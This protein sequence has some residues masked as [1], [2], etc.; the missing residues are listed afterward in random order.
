VAEKRRRDRM[1]SAS[2][3]YAIVTGASSGLGKAIAGEL[4]GRGHNLVLID[5]PGTGLKEVCS[6]LEKVC[7]IVTHC[8]EA[9]MCK[10]ETAGLIKEFTS[11][12][13]FDI[14]ILINNVGIGYGGEIGQYNEESISETVFLNI[15]SATLLT[16]YFIAELKSHTP[17]FILNMGSFSGF[18]PMPYKSIYSASKAYIYHFSLSVREELHGTGVSVSVAMPGPVKTNRKVCERIA[19]VGKG[20][21]ISSLE[22]DEAAREIITQMFRRRR[23]IVPGKS[24]K[25]LYGIESFLPYG[26]IMRMTR[27]AFKGID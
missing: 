9:D 21:I 10:P 13:G 23:L 8:F 18:V 17:S 3:L 25:M 2:D 24:Y 5:L 19:A 7:S 22:A 27:N 20:A 14:D 1:T 26:L 11:S 15:R 12:K 4:A 6:G 16:N